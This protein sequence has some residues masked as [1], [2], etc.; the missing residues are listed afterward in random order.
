ML[1][2]HPP[3][4]LH[5]RCKATTIIIIDPLSNSSDLLDIIGM[6]KQRKVPY[7]LHMLVEVTES[8]IEAM[9]GT[10]QA[11]RHKLES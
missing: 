1:D 6:Q 11:G 4:Y 3:C 8:I 9:V 10:P 7:F 2:L 5:P